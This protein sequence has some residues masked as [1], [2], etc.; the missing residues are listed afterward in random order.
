MTMGVEIEVAIIDAQSKALVNGCPRILESLT[1]LD[2]SRIKPELMQCYIEANSE[3][4]INASEAEAD[5]AS[6][7]TTIESAADDLGL[8]LFWS[9][10]HPF[11]MWQDQEVTANDRYHNLVGLLQD[12]ARQLVTFG[13]HVHVGVDSGD[14]AVM[15]CDRMLNHLPTLLAASCNSPN[16]N[17]RDTG[18]QSWRSRVMDALPTAGLPP[19]MRNWSEYVWL[20]N[21]HI[22]TGFIESIREIWWDLR[23]HHN[24]G[25]VEIRICDVPGNLKDA[26]GLAGLIH[27]TVKHLSDEI[28]EGTYQHDCHPMIVRQNKWRAARYGLEAQLV[29]SKTYELHSARDTIRALVEKVRPAAEK[30][31]SAHHLDHV[32]EMIKLPNWSQRQLDLLEKSKDPNQAISELVQL[33]RI[34]ERK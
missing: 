14:K 17:G 18:L 28:D 11:S 22:Q 13:L 16:W 27:S 29:D 4:C 19:L 26:I 23:P 8:E 33:S 30:L 9:A 34:Q 25:T 12:T 6:K 1:D 32:L 3:V 31:D 21:H 24:F 5:L 15:I 20:V 7:F 10:T 2:R